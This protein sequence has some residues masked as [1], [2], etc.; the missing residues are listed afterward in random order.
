VAISPARTVIDIG[1]ELGIDAAIVSADSLLRDGLAT[2][3]ELAAA[4]DCCSGWPG[5]TAS[6]RAVELADERAES[7]LESLSRLRIID[8]R[9]PAPEPQM[10]ILDHAGH[11]CG[12]V[13]F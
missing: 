6:A 12:R 11:F 8:S 2:R 4:L 3:D 1:W 10:T 13:D 5:V 9:L 7:V